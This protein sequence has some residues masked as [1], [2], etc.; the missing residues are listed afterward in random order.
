MKDENGKELDNIPNRYAKLFGADMKSK[1]D[2][3][4]LNI[5]SEAIYVTINANEVYPEC[6]IKGGTMHEHQNIRHLISTLKK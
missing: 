5:T 2:D 4:G 3:Y 1:L 6:F